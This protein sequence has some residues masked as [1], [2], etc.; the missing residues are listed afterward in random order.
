M[1]N[2]F[3]SILAKINTVRNAKADKAS[4]FKGSMGLRKGNIT[5]ND[6]DRLTSYR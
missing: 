5:S 1:E 4:A 3:T 6:R 2:Q